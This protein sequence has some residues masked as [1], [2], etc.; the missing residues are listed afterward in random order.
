MLQLKT[1]SKH[2]NNKTINV[3]KCRFKSHFSL[4]I[5]AKK[6]AKTKGPV[7]IT[8]GEMMSLCIDI[9]AQHKIVINKGIIK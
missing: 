4:Y 3:L 7:N 5:Q 2:P 9:Y 8:D 1:N 6:Q